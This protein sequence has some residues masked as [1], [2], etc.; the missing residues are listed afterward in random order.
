MKIPVFRSPKAA[1]VPEMGSAPPHIQIYILSEYH[2]GGRVGV[3][4]AIPAPPACAR[5]QYANSEYNCMGKTRTKKT[6][7]WEC[8]YITMG[9]AVYGY[10]SYEFL[11]LGGWILKW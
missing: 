7:G 9:T 10:I 6:V 8:M 4:H 11:G 1:L 2:S 3:Q 5:A